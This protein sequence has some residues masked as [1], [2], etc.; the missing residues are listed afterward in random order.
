MDGPK[1]VIANFGIPGFSCDPAGNGFANAA[2]VTH[3]VDEALGVIP[4]TDN[5]AGNNFVSVVD[6][7]IVIDAAIGLGCFAGYH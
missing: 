1:S 7:Q 3:V 6:I 5:L 4:A 2:D